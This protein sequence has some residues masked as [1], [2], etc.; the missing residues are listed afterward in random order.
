MVDMIDEDRLSEV[1]RTDVNVRLVEPHLYSLYPPGEKTNPYDQMGSIYDLVACNALYN[2]LLWGYS[3]SEYHPLCLEALESSAD[4]WVLD[5]RCGSLAFTAR[6]YASHYR[7]P[8]VFLDQSIKMLGAAKT[9]LA[10]L[11]GGGP[12]NM[13]FL[14]GDIL[15]L[16]FKPKSFRTVISLNV[17]HVLAD[18]PRVITG[19][20]E[21][22]ADGGTISLTTLV[23]NNRFADRY[24]R[25][26]GR[27]GAAVPRSADQLLAVF[28]A[29]GMPVACRIRGNLAFI[30][31]GST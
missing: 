1:L 26:L 18:A 31:Y 28:D 19:L 22:L 30:Q 29:L 4:G 14:H 11:M 9:R 17:L 2:R 10:E 23:Q 16:P 3:I 21:A 20:R 12:E 13:V 25:M 8:I 27:M 7:R 5:A 24:L 6:T 15:E